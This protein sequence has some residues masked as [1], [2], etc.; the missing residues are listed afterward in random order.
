[1]R[2]VLLFA[3]SCLVV[4]LA[5]AP[6]AHAQWNVDEK[7]EL[8]TKPLKALKASGLVAYKKGVK[9]MSEGARGQGQ[10]ALRR[11]VKDLAKVYEARPLNGKNLFTLANSYER[12]GALKEA[13]LFY[14]KLDAACRSNCGWNIPDKYRQAIKASKTSIQVDLQEEGLKYRQLTSQ[15]LGKC[16]E[17]CELDYVNEGGSGVTMPKAVGYPILW[18]F[19]GHVGDAQFVCKGKGNVWLSFMGNNES[20]C[21]SSNGIV[22]APAG[23]DDGHWKWKTSTTLI[24]AST[25]VVGGGLLGAGGVIHSQGESALDDASAVYKKD[26][27]SDVYFKA[28]SDSLNGKT[29]TGNMLLGLGA[30]AL[31]MGAA[32]TVFD[33]WRSD[34]AGSDQTTL[35]PVYDGD[36]VGVQF[37]WAF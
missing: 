21:G 26:G 30:G 18:W 37:N 36:G 3:V 19:K 23:F 20:K 28:I 31:A 1:M 6:L 22:D 35:V 32:W 2:R 25:V 11:A 10:T 33:W 7:V 14:W 8:D 34:V 24:A 29:V 16:A 9:L 12:L 15:M 17:R 4:L 13:Y 27:N 5:A